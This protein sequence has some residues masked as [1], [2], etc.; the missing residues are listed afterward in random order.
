M[1]TDS[2]IA[3]VMDISDS[4]TSL[5][6]GDIQAI[7]S[8]ALIE[9]YMLDVSVL[10]GIAANYMYFHA[11]TNKLSTPVVW[12]G[13]TYI[14]LPIETE[15]FSSGSTG[16]LPRPKI[17]LANADGAFSATLTRFD[18]LIGAKVTRKRTFVKYLD[19]VN[20]PNG[21][22]AT[23]DPNQHYPDDTWF[24]DQ[25]LSE[26]RYIIEWELASAFDLIG[27]MLPSRQV[28]QNSCPWKYTGAECGYNPNAGG[29]KLFNAV[30][31]QVYILANDVCGK[32]LT[33]CEARFG[34]SA[35]LPYGGY[36]GA[37][38]YG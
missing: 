34:T 16:S 26:T 19:A 22:N 18:D 3:N 11:G 4:T 28:H 24:I 27:V 30:D 8:N 12:Q 21:V 20:F 7:A 5:I 29:A 25:K 38:Q 33:S 32:R 1:A 10:T 6:Q 17:R 13:H 31:G 35:V 23:A 14:A 36:P 15:G 2:F 9:L 37:M